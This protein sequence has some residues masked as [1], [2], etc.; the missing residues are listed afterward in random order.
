MH[1]LPFEYGTRWMH[2]SGPFLVPIT[3]PLFMPQRL[4][5]TKKCR[6]CN[7]EF[8][9]EMMRLDPN[10]SIR[11]RI[12]QDCRTKQFE[13]LP[14]RGPA[15]WQKYHKY[16]TNKCSRCDFEGV[17]VQFDIHH[18][19]QNH[20]NNDPSNLENLCAN[21]HRLQTWLNGQEKRRQSLLGD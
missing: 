8:P 6:V 18:I 5:L 20:K 11:D 19:D 10:G 13:L 3:S 15:S 1:L 21:C 17:I 7:V 4:E 2:L 9:R 16:R 14:K 12:C